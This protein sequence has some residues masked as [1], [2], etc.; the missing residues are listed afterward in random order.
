MAKDYTD[1]ANQIVAK[2]GGKENVVSVTN[3]MT[4]LRFKL[5]DE[6]KANTESVKKIKGVQG[7]VLQG[8]QYQIVIGTHVKDVIKYVDKVLEQAENKK[9]SEKETKKEGIFNKL[10]QII[11]GCVVSMIPALI[12]SGVIKG[13]LAILTTTG[14]LTTTDGT[15]IILYGAANAAMFFMPILIGFNA[16]KVFGCN[17]M[18]AATI[19]AALVYPSLSNL[20]TMIHPEY[21]NVEPAAST[22]SFLG[23][24]VQLIDYSN[25]MLPIILAVFLASIIQKQAEKIIPQIL[26]LVFVPAVT[27]VITVPISFLVIGPVMTMVSNGLSTICMFVYNHVLCSAWNPRCNYSDLI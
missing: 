13:V 2:I 5:K 17:Q 6:G 11:A 19:G 24:P 10:F 9:T 7:V 16:G 27:L 22:I 18:I 23:I 15:Y 26:Q 3:C 14:V 20:L 12:A 25:S 8:G 4:R 21:A 1:L